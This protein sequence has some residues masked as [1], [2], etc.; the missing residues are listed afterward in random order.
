[1]LAFV[2]QSQKQGQRFE[3]DVRHH[4]LK[5]TTMKKAGGARH[6]AIRASARPNHELGYGGPPEPVRQRENCW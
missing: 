3:E 2:K 1:M 5:S 4:V 6:I